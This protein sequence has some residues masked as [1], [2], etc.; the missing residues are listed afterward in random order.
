MS[1]W[2]SCI[3]R[4]QVTCRRL[5]FTATASVLASA[6]S[7]LGYMSAWIIKW[8]DIDLIHIPHFV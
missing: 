2:N 4:E 5:D 7:F 3:C 6:L 1:C 8:E